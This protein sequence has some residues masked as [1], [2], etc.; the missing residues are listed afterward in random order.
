[1]CRVK[2]VKYTLCA[3]RTLLALAPCDRYP[4]ATLDSSQLDEHDTNFG[5][6]SGNCPKC[7]MERAQEELAWRNNAGSSGRRGGRDGGRS[8]RDD[9]GR[10]GG[11]GVEEAVRMIEK[12]GDALGWF[13]SRTGVLVP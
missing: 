12:W 9:G 2:H 13:R 10:R 4:C 1:M 5:F 7:Q 6:A 3:H 11:L 8:G